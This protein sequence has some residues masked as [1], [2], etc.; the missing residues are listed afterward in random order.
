MNKNAYSAL[1]SSLDGKEENAIYLGI[2]LPP[3]KARLK[4]SIVFSKRKFAGHSGHAN[5]YLL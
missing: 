4:V 3:R 2:Y 5:L 1:S